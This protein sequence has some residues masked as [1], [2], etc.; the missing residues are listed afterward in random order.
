MINTYIIIFY[1]QLIGNNVFSFS[2][3]SRYEFEEI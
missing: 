3:K 1:F 2:E